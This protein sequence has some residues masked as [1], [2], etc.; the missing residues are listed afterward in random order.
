VAQRKRRRTRSKG[1]KVALAHFEETGGG[2]AF[3]SQAAPGR[4][5]ARG[6]AAFAW[7]RVLQMQADVQDQK[8]V[9]LKWKRSFAR[10]KSW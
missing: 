9:S 7:H 5:A 8:I 2:A 4:R 10:Q 1:E 6:G 3:L